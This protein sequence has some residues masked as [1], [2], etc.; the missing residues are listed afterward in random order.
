LANKRPIKGKRQA[1]TYVARASRT[2]NP[3][4][5][6]KRGYSLAWRQFHLE[7]FTQRTRGERREQQQEMDRE[8]EKRAEELKRVRSLFLVGAETTLGVV[9][10][11]G[12]S[13]LD[14]RQFR[15]PK[16][17]PFLP[18]SP[19]IVRSLPS[20]SEINYPRSRDD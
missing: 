2:K 8:A 15:F 17:P 20:S 19:G 3:I 13:F 11:A 5:P 12:E 1:Q 7:S 6:K 4:L 10:R 14:L 18:L 16:L 9:S